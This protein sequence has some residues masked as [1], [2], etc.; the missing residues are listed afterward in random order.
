MESQRSS[1]SRSTVYQLGVQGAQI[2]A[3]CFIKGVRTQARLF[4]GTSAEAACG[5]VPSAFRMLK[6]RERTA[7]PGKKRRYLPSNSYL[8]VSRSQSEPF[9]NPWST[10]S[11]AAARAVLTGGGRRENAADAGTARRRRQ[12]RWR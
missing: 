1:K 8:I 11:Q 5:R 3:Q 2:A 10:Q 6:V 12:P 7:E 9:T 4:C